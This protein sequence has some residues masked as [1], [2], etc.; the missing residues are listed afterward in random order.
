M[1][2][3]GVE[4]CF[5]LLRWFSSSLVPITGKL[6]WQAFLPAPAGRRRRIKEQ[7]GEHF[8]HPKQARLIVCC[9]VAMGS[10]QGNVFWLRWLWDTEFSPWWVCPAAASEC[11]FCP[12]HLGCLSG[13]AHPSDFYLA[14]RCVCG[15]F[16][17]FSEFLFFAWPQHQ[18]M[19]G[20]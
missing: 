19:N 5:M 2:Q 1:F 20:A 4:R 10:V 13:A 17:F 7:S 12:D 8:P 14:M 18:L 16:F 3:G 9:G 15:F 11:F 6:C